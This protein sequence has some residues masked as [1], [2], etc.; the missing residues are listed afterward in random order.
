MEG[1]TE[2]PFPLLDGHGVDGRR[3]TA[4]VTDG[5]TPVRVEVQKSRGFL[6]LAREE[7]GWGEK[8]ERSGGGRGLGLGFGVE[9]RGD[10]GG[11]GAE[12]AHMGLMVL[13]E[14]P[15]LSLL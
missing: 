9:R 4:A 2:V 10:K 1:I 14:I 12:L 6:R 7:K 3:D 11:R 13:G 8:R 5:G 15:S